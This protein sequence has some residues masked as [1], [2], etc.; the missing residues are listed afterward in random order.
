MPAEFRD[1]VIVLNSRFVP[2]A[3]GA[4][5][6][7]GASQHALHVASLLRRLGQRVGFVLY[8]RRDG[9]AVPRVEERSV[10]DTYPAAELYYD[11][12]TEAA[13]R[14][15]L[16]RAVRSVAGSWGPIRR[17]SGHLGPLVYLQTPVL[18]PYLERGPDVLVTHHGP[19]VPD[20]R[21]ALGLE[22]ARE[23]FDWDHP[24]ADFL[25]R[26]QARALQVVKHRDA[27]HCGEIS[28]LQVRFLR[29]AG[30]PPWRIHRLP[31]PVAAEKG[32]SSVPDELRD[33]VGRL[34]ARGSPVA[35]TAV[36]RLDSFKNVELFVLGC[37]LALRQRTIA[38]AL[39][40][41]GLPHEPER[42]RLAALVPPDLSGLV[43]FLPRQPRAAVAGWLFP[44]L[45][46]RG[47]FACT[48]RFDLVPYT[49]LE[50]ARAGLTTLVPDSPYVGAAAYL[51]ERYRFR[52]DPHGLAAAFRD[53][54]LG[55]SLSEGFADVARRIAASTSDGAFTEAFRN[56][57]CAI[58]Q[59]RVIPSPDSA[60]S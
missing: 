30:V 56:V 2:E 45:A 19:F 4:V 31:P 39:V 46:E 8:R 57:L 50:A 23:A 40:V 47:V 25:A 36:A 44:A 12:R 43:R 16:S 7:Y 18:L 20:V 6:P 58:Q 11:P 55:P 33:L 54:G 27:V 34:T 32:L 42:D 28:D 48:S 37:V 1:T 41:G 17:D 10:L 24:K 13:V 22:R 15:G 35:V 51:P 26:M 3:V 53:V 38:G 60:T 14:A 9:L 49:V 52:P 21:E 29:R 59:A 5:Y